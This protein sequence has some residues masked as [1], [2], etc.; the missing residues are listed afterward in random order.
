MSLLVGTP[1]LR[2]INSPDPVF[3]LGLELAVADSVPGLSNLVAMLLND[4]TD[5]GF[6]HRHLAPFGMKPI[7]CIGNLAATVMRHQRFQANDFLLDPVGLGPTPDR[8]CF[9]GDCG[10]SVVRG[11]AL[12]KAKG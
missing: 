1:G 8:R 10:C 4:T 11:R 12:I 6:S 7:K 2:K 3:W 9:C 5:I